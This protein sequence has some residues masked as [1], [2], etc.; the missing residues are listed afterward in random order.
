MSKIVLFIFILSSIIA[1]NWGHRA[2]VD[3]YTNLP[4]NSLYILEKSL[5]TIQDNENFVYLEFDIQET[6]DGKIV[7]F[8]DKKLKRM[9]PNAGDNREIFSV[10]YQKQKF[11]ERMKQLY[12]KTPKA[13][14]LKIAD[15]TLS[16]LKTLYLN[17]NKDNLQQ[18]I[19]ELSEFLASCEKHKLIKPMVVEIK[20]LKTEEA[21]ED[22]FNEILVFR[23]RYVSQIN[24]IKE[25]DYDFPFEIG[26][27]CF[28]SN[29]TSSYGSKE[30]RERWCQILKDHDFYGMF[31][32]ITHWSHCGLEKNAQK[33]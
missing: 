26:F 19:P 22:L 14:D 5:N 31:M 8:H 29:W 4:E 6:F 28:Y 30:N 27:M 9:L 10:L 3:H 15:L 13:H 18:R 11:I 16:E 33:Q 20:Y 32:P 2:G 7:V 1:E 17:G 23:D 25:K 21:R 12:G 24:V